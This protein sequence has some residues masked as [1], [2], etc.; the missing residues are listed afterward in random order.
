MSSPEGTARPSQVTAA[1]WGVAIA[2]FMLVISVFDSMANLKSVDMRAEITRAVTSGS[3]KGLGLSVEEATEVLR[4][5][6]F[7][8]GFAGVAAAILGIYV[9]QRNKSARIGLTVAAVPIVLTAPLAGSFP[10]MFIAAGTAILW[11][12]PARDWFAGRQPTARKRPETA[13]AAVQ[14]FPRFP[15]NAPPQPPSAQPPSAQP[16]GAQYPPPQYPAPQVPGDQPPPTIGWGQ[17]PPPGPPAPFPPAPNPYGYYPPAPRYDGPPLPTGD[18]PREVRIAVI[19]TWVF[20]AITALGNLAVLAVVA[21]DSQGLVD[22]IKDSPGWNSSYDEDLLVTATVAG[23]IVF[24][25]W[26]VAAATLAFLVWRRVRW[27]W[28]LL[29]VSSGMAALFSILAFPFSLLHLVAIAVVFG[30]LLNRRSRDW[31]RG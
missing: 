19:V 26:C 18:R 12:R 13:S 27:A 4:W 30:M 23:S 28:V 10:G 29:L 15:Q 17:V 7:V 22:R 11:T 14:E 3:A 9:L 25:V 20:A 2:A 8:A 1:G 6:L 5:C 31:F 24:V 21:V 16:P